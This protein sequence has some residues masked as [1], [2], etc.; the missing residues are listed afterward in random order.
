M[1]S[2]TEAGG[3]HDSDLSETNVQFSVETPHFPTLTRCTSTP[4]DG[5][6][7]IFASPTNEINADSG[8]ESG[9]DLSVAGTSLDKSGNKGAI[10]K[11]TRSIITRS[12]TRHWSGS[13]Q[14][15]PT[16]SSSSSILKSWLSFNLRKYP[17]DDPTDFEKKPRFVYTPGLFVGREKLDIIKRLNDM[18]THHILTQIWKYLSIQDI[19][20]VLQVSLSWNTAIIVDYDAMEKYKKAK[21]SFDENPVEHL[22]NQERIR[23]SKL[24]PRKALTAVSNLLLSP[25][26]RVPP[27]QRR[28]P[29]LNIS[30]S[31]E[32]FKPLIVSPSKFRHRLFAEEAQRL[33]PDEKLQPCPRCTCP[34][35]VTPNEGKAQCSRI[36]CQYEFCIYCMC[37]YHS[38]SPCRITRGCK[39]K[40]TPSNHPTSPS[41]STTSS[42]SSGSFTKARVTS[43]V[44]KRRLK[45]L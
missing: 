19:A 8:F 29:R 36:S 12:R 14:S 35:R 3:S 24:S 13:S 27:E 18:G 20:K 41:S 25:V 44:S 7:L 16:S 38:G 4:Q 17:K 15:T 43:K 21:E 6:I 5:K 32:I 28:S 1:A 23:L 33:A 11:K 42:A 2:N 34:S 22:E 39:M 37:S 45:R 30:G 31:N 9:I 40:G 10:P 26:K